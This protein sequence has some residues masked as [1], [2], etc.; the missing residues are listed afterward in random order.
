M[1]KFVYVV[2]I[3]RDSHGRMLLRE[4]LNRQDVSRLGIAPPIKPYLFFGVLTLM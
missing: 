4:R 2:V 1:G 3:P